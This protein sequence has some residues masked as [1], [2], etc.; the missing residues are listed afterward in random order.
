VAHDTIAL[1]SDNPD[2][3]ASKEIIR[4]HMQ[5]VASMFAQG[6]FSLPTFVHDTVPPG[7]EAMKH[8]KDQIRYTDL[9]SQTAI[10]PYPFYPMLSQGWGLLW[11]RNVRSPPSVTPAADHLPP[12]M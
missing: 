7:V 3:D 8:L 9:S 2:D 5:K 1:E 6:D 4:R 11:V 12:S 10:G